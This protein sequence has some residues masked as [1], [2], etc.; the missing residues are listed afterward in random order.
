VALCVARV[1]VER[2]V[3]GDVNEEGTPRVCMAEDLLD[4]NDDTLCRGVEDG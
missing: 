2:A 3:V 1:D 4:P